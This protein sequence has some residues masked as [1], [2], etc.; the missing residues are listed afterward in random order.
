M[1]LSRISSSTNFSVRI[2]RRRMKE[3]ATKLVSNWVINSFGSLDRLFLCFVFCT[4]IV[5]PKGFFIVTPVNGYESNNS[6]RTQEAVIDFCLIKNRPNPGRFVATTFQ[7]SKPLQ[8]EINEIKAKAS[9]K[10]P[11][12]FSS[13]IRAESEIRRI[14]LE[15]EKCKWDRWHASGA[16]FH[17]FQRL[18]L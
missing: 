7:R 16:D 18:Y 1:F 13:V 3:L 15:I 14:M 8:R 17:S 12:S 5:C 10:M 11:K 6:S 4:K 9:W 2:F